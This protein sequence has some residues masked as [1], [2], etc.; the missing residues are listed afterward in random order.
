MLRRTEWF[1]QAGWERGAAAAL[2]SGKRQLTPDEE[3]DVFQARLQ[4]F[5][6][7][8]LPQ[9]IERTYVW[10]EIRNP[11]TEETYDLKHN[12]DLKH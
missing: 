3:R 12:H 5:L 11:M 1:E 4:P 6:G 7:V 9:K 10:K 8:L 2:V